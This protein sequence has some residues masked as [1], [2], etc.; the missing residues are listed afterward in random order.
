MVNRKR[1]LTIGAIPASLLLLG[2]ASW[3]IGRVVP[4]SSL[5]APQ[6]VHARPE[7]LN[8]ACPA[9]IVDPFHLDGGVSAASVWNSAGERETSGE[10]TILRADAS[11]HTL[12]TT[13]GVMGQSGGE[14]RGL[15]MTSCQLPANDQW[16][17][18]GS[19]TSGED[20]VLT[21]ANPNSSPSVVTLEGYGANGPIDAKPHQMTIPARSTQSVLAGGL[22]PEESALAV[23]IHADGQGVA[24]WV[25]SSAMQGEVPKGVTSVSG[26][27][28]REDQ[29]FLGLSKQGSSSLRLLVPPSAADDEADTHVALSYTS[30]AGTFNVPGGELDVS[31]GTV[32]DVPLSGMTD[33]RYTLRVHGDRALVAQI[34]TN[35]E[36]EEYSEGSRW[37]MRSSIAA[38]PALIRAEL[39]SSQRVESMVRESLSASALRA[40]AQEKPS[41]VS[42]IHSRLIITPVHSQSGVQLSLGTQ[43]VTVEAGKTLSMDLPS[44]DSVV[45]ESPSQVAVALEVEAQTPS[46]TLRA[47]WPL[48]ADD[49][50][51][52]SAA[53]T[54][55]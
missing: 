23:H 4:E 22:F 19:S 33:D 34:V 3:G 50:E 43:T 35:T 26:T 15:S 44:A 29:L 5:P 42:E 51:Q 49:V 12:P 14:L 17:V 31:A 13:L 2:T 46:G 20:L 27:K 1:M 52:A 18:L 24:T 48:S 25:Q 21:F 9:G 45:L 55:N 10:W 39:P 28:P 30:D 36:Q 7:T 40:T 37:A 47:L 16:S 38:S 8:Y 54:I 11:A 53:I 32:V 6:V 41:G